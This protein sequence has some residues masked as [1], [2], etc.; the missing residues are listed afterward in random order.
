M[1]ASTFR[2]ASLL[3]LS[4]LAAAAGEA[5]PRRPADATRAHV[6]SFRA[7]GTPEPTAREVEGC[8]RVVARQAATL[9]GAPQARIR[10]A[11]HVITC[12]G[13]GNVSDEAIDAQIDELNRAFRGTGYSFER[14]GVDRSED[15]SWFEMSVGGDAER[16]AKRALAVDPVRTLNLY[17]CRPG[18]YLLGWAYLPFALPEDGVLD[19]V[20]VHFESL[21]GGG[22][23]AFDLGRTAVHEVGHYLGLYHTFQNGCNPPGDEVDDTPFEAAPAAGCPTE[24]NTCSQPGLD[25]VANYMDYSD[26]R[27]LTTFTPGQS[28][29]MDAIAPVYR[30][31]LFSA[32]L[33]SSVRRRR[34]YFAEAG[35]M[36]AARAP[37]V[38]S[39]LAR[40]AHGASEP[41]G[42][43]RPWFEGATPNPFCDRTE[44]V[45]SLPRRTRVS[46]RLHALSGRAARTVASRTLAAGTHHIPFE[47][48]DLAAGL[49]LVEMKAGGVAQTRTVLV[50]P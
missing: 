5:A 44:M 9:A 23:P 22:L 4:T 49:Y 30:P 28:A 27:C 18:G 40:T 24:R 33:A 34:P 37:A 35:P 13:Y 1:T 25:P 50:V 8:R 38:S 21:P 14:A 2:L 48:G 7:C 20:V 16:R 43:G 10:V 11:F 3:V 15:C 32:P 29:R 45:V 36:V 46:L 39:T 42:L 26:D 17:T 47:T 41:P 12:S 19:G 6:P 31:G